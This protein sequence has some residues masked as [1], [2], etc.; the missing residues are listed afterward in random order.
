MVL[1]DETIESRL[2]I[3]I[4][5]LSERVGSRAGA[6]LSKNEGMKAVGGSWVMMVVVECE[7]VESSRGSRARG[8]ASTQK[9]L[10]VCQL[11]SE[12]V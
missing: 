7:W 8:E 9:H 2:Y 6:L 4:V 12:P 11:R 5:L 3:P 1:Q 10:N